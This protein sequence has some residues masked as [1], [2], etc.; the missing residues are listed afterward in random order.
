MGFHIVTDSNADLSAADRES[1][2]DFSYLH[3][4]YFINDV[5]GDP[6]I[7]GHEFFEAMRNGANS[8]EIGRASCRERV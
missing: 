3:V 1:F 4:P 2:S 8:A 6:G 5:E 7:T